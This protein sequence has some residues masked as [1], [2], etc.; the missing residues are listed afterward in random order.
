MKRVAYSIETKI[1]VIEMQI[2]EY[3]TEEIMEKLNIRNKTQVNTWWRWYR[4]SETH[5]FYQHVGKQYS[6]RK[7]SVKLNNE[8]LLKITLK[9]ILK[10]LITKLM[11]TP[12]CLIRSLPF[13]F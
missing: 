8:E 10:I 9:P 2:K 11:P 5:R 6:Y 7:G 4:N 1:K 12:Y 13:Y 3:R